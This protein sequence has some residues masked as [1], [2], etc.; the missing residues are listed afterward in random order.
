MILRCIRYLP[1]FLLGAQEKR[2]RRTCLCFL[3]CHWLTFPAQLL[4][5]HQCVRSVSAKKQ[6]ESVR[7]GKPCATLQARAGRVSPSR[8]QAEM[9]RLAASV[10]A[11]EAVLWYTVTTT[12]RLCF[13]LHVK[14]DQIGVPCFGM[15]ATH[16]WQRSRQG[17]Y[18][19]EIVC[20]DKT[21]PACMTKHTP[22]TAME[23][24]TRGKKDMCVVVS[25]KGRAY[26]CTTSS[27]KG[28]TGN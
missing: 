13:Y 15:T 12:T 8:E 21:C 23:N 24:C 20:A 27:A 14:C 19:N 26:L 18:A 9:P 3:L 11:L 22:S 5:K 2:P 28:I 4:P 25:T 7:A 6:Y 10:N 16:K 1:K 17:L